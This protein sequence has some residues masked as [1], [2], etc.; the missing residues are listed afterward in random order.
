MYVEKSNLIK[1][2]LYKE[3]SDKGCVNN[4]YRSLVRLYDAFCNTYNKELYLVGGCVRD[5][6]LN[7][8]PK[9]YDLCTNATP[10][11]VKEILKQIGFGCVDTGIKHGTVTALDYE[12]N[13]SFEI[14]TYRTDGKYMDGRHPDSVTF[15]PSLEEDLKRRDFTINSFA[16]D[17]LK[18]ELV[19]L[20]KSFLNDLNQKTI[21][22]VGE[23]TERFNEDALRILR[24]IRFSAQLNFTIAADTYAAIELRKEKLSLISKERIRDELTKIVLSNNPEN[25][26]YVVILDLEKYIFD[27]KTPFKDCLAC[28]HENDWH[29]TD[30]FHHILDVVKKTR[31]KFNLRW[32][33]LFHDIGKP[34]NKRL[35]EGSTN[36]YTYNGHP[37]TSAEM[38]IELMEMLKFTNEQIDTISKFVKYHDMD[39]QEVKNSTFKR[40]VVDIGVDNFPDFIELRYADAFSHQLT[41]HLT[42]G[43]KYVIDAIDKVKER[44]YSCTVKDAVLTLKDLKVNGFDMLDLG[45]KGPEIGK[46]LNE[47]LELVLNGDIENKKDVLI[48]F[49]KNKE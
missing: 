44:F 18:E 21:R 49:I 34:S 45:L 47:L 25:L 35:K 33:A 2:R 20:D 17:F 14:T 15:T 5:M 27:G 29:Y 1:E 16:Y 11:E 9:D 19:M 23:A 4:I 38:A 46:A 43:T 40:I 31:P 48:N 26:I 32:A 6:L 41:N 24:A 12:Y 30:V 10:L 7:K 28:E 13:T 36:R 22:C 42:K 8:T 3:F 39:L 37:D